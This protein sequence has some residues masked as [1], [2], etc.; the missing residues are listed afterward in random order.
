MAKTLLDGVN[1][2]L[3]KTA[4]LDSD[5]GLLQSLTDSSRQ[6]YVDS[7]IQVLNECVDELYSVA[8]KA[9]PLALAEA[10]ITLATGDRDYALAQDLITLRREFH[11]ID[12]TNNHLIGILPDDGYWQLVRVDIEQNDTGLPHAAAI[13]PTDGQLFMD[14]A[15]TANENGRVYKYRYD[16]DL[17]LTLA[18][19][20]FPFSNAVFRAI[21]PAAAEL[22]KFYNHHEFTQ[23][24]F[25]ASIARA[26]R[27]LAQIPARDS[28]MP[29]VAGRN[30]TDPLEP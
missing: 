25:D 27:L 6:I 5:S 4:Y 14:R 2:V 26:A 22:W 19:D 11:L 20:E 29:R 17:E 28:W 1:E 15:P 13:R 9:K 23:G 24:I 8:G 30:I 18:A 16:K 3:K 21:I 12:E 7:A 10:T